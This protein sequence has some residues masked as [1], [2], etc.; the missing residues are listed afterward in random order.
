[1]IETVLNLLKK[2]GILVLV[3]LGA[4]LAAQDA[5]TAMSETELRSLVP[6]PADAA[7]K[8]SECEKKSYPTCTYVWG[9]P[10]ED[11]AMRIELGGSPSGDKLMT[12][13][14]QAR[15]IQEFDRVLS[16][17]RDAVPVE[18]LGVTAVWSDMRKQLSLIT[19]D[20]LVIH[21]NVDIWMLEDPRTTAEQVAAFLLTVQ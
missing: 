17:Y 10:D 14:A 9:Y 2:L 21:V 11:D 3:S 16:S 4:P 19:E 13:F 7:L 12:I 1:M 6:I 8:L 5:F 20:S 18:G 15:N